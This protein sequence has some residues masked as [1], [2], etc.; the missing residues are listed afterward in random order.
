[1]GFAL[2]L[3]YVL[4]M[5]IRPQ[6]LNPAWASYRFMDV[7]AGLAVAGTLISIGMGHRPHLGGPAFPLGLSFLV[8][9]AFTVAAATRW[10]GG[11]LMTLYSLSVSFFVFLLVTLNVTTRRRLKILVALACG[12]LLAVLAQ[13]AHAYYSDA[14]ESPFFLVM[15]ARGDIDAMV[16][17]PEPT[18]VPDPD[19]ESEEG[20]RIRPM[21]KRIRGLGF[22]ADP[23]D[24]AQAFVSAVPLV[25][26][27]WRRRR[28]V[29]NTAFVLLP[30]G[31]LVWG[32]LLTRSRGALVALAVLPVAAALAK[33][34]RRH[35][36]PAM[37]TAVLIS[38]PAF[39]ILFGYAKADESAYSRLEA[40]SAGLLMLRSSPVWGV[41]SG[42]FTEHHERVAHNSFVQCFAETGLVG[43][44]L[45]LG[46]VVMTL[47][48]LSAV[49]DFA[50]DADSARWASALRL[51][52]V[53]FLVAALFLSRTT[54]PLLFFLAS[55]PAALVG[56]VAREERVA[57]GGRW[58][59]QTPLLEAASIVL[60]WVTA[61]A[62]H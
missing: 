26:L 34:R 52:L 31:A 21:V 49:G 44:F 17:S 18:A 8:W 29:R 12:S 39:I 32:I 60:V 16:D 22:L 2:T 46:L 24:L 38:I 50:A 58:W 33:L 56:M 7:L 51:S 5:F 3:V 36:R 23:N 6:E 55:L 45:W 59:L 30:V 61:R 25:F 43:Y 54:S 28:V 37:A 27:L 41:G 62:S 57:F 1:M 53:A 42:L 35:R 4:F 10:F 48:Q 13:A 20:S 14:R 19:E 15:E 11:A 47:K 9:S 40:W